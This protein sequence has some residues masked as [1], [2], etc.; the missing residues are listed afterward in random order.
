MCNASENGIL[1]LQMGQSL[2][3]HRGGGSFTLQKSIAAAPHS[4][5]P[6]GR[7][8]RPL[9]ILLPGSPLDIQSLNSVTERDHHAVGALPG[10]PL[11]TFLCSPGHRCCTFGTT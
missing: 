2:G 1:A 8:P 7:L 10:I 11:P 4:S 9:S 3:S 6:F 5:K